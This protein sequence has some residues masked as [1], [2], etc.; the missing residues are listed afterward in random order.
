MLMIEES[1]QA[2][3]VETEEITPTIKVIS[4]QVRSQIST[5]N[6]TTTSQET[7]LMVHTEPMPQ[8][9][10]LPRKTLVNVTNKAKSQLI[11]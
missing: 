4:T 2:S 8:E 10:L 3:K 5:R 7:H 1:T 9:I 11:F 6:P